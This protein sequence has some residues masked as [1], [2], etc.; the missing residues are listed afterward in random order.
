MAHGQLATFR[1]RCNETA[2]QEG[3]AGPGHGGQGSQVSRLAQN[4]EL[5]LPDGE[6][7]VPE[8]RFPGVELQHLDPV[9]NL[10]HQLDAFVLVL[11]LL[12]LQNTESK[13]MNRSF[14][15][16]SFSHNYQNEK[17]TKKIDF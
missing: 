16:N 11:H 3:G 10:I 17:Q 4:I 14:P 7:L 12:H 6:D 9:Q 15:A 1:H 8:G 2:Y 5:F 13:R